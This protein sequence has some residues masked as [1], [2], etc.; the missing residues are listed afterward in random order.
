MNWL[1]I[2]SLTDLNKAVENSNMEKNKA[3]LIFKHS[4][5][6]AISSTVK[7]RLESFWKNDDNFPTYYLD[8]IKFR[9]LSDQIANNFSV[10]H[11]SPQVLV[12][13]D[14]KCVY[15]SSHLSISVKDILAS[16]KN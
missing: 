7:Y 6:C 2:E 11:E 5:R 10:Y 14:G 16:V 9:E 15:N 3:I 12:I 8:L 13:K 1:A 4:T